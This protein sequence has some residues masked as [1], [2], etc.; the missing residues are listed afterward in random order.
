MK[1]KA[2]TEQ[3]LVEKISDVYLTLMLS[4][5]LLW[6]GTA[7]YTAITAAKYRLFLILTLAYCAG[8]LLLYLE[9]LAA[10][11]LRLHP[12]KAFLR[13]V[14]LPE[15]LMTGYVLCSFIA[16][17]LSPWR[18]DAWL[19]LTRCE[20]FLTLALYAAVFVLLGRFARPKKWLLDVFAA[21]MS[22]NCLL[23]LWQLLGGNPLHLYPAGL[24]YYDAGSAYSG[25]YLGTIGNTDLL[26]AVF[27]VA[28]PAF[29][30]GAWKLRRYWL[31]GPAVLCMAVAVWMDVSAGLLGIAAGIIL[32]VPLALR[33]KARCAA[34]LAIGAAFLAGV[35][36]V[37]FLP[38]LPGIFGQAHALLHGQADDTFG[39]GRIYIWKNVWQAVKERP[40]FGGGP[41]TLSRRITAYFE[42]Y[43]EAHG[44]MIQTGIDAAHNEY[45]NILANQGVFALLFWLG[46]LICS[47]VRF[48]C[49]GGQEMHVLICGSAVLGYCVQAFFGI[50]MCISAPFFVLAWALLENRT[51]A[52]MLHCNSKQIKKN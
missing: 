39:S 10:Q 24:T 30:Y 22:V 28:V 1:K 16:T 49:R 41:D 36:A 40:F 12:V 46:T 51:T 50:S 23:A 52:G 45:L 47:A 15:W 8:L 25:M 35:I 7:G 44:R 34:A 31:L 43:D 9:L 6:P 37:F 14:R 42:R 4:V 5:F 20:G 48:V 17:I 13:G 19:G 18:T 2:Q 26:A 33:G 38:G 29:F 32:P 11:Q 21:A 27:C 3:L